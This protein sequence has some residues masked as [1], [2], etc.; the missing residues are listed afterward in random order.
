M[1]KSITPD[2]ISTILSNPSPDSS[3][4]L[5]EIIVQVIDLT[6]IG[7]RYKFTAN[8]GKMKLKAMFPSSFSSEINSGNIQNLG[9]IQVIDYTLNDIPSK[10][11]K[12]LIVTKCE[13]VSPALE[14]EF[15]TEVKSEETGILLKP[16]QVVEIQNEVKGEGT[17]I[18]LKPKQEIVAKSA[19][20]IVNEQHGNMAPAARMAMTRRVHPL[21]SLNPYQGNWTIKVRLTNKGTMCTY[22]NARGEGC[23]F[24]VELTDEDGTQIQ[25]TM[26]NEAARKFYEKFQLGKVYY[27]SKGALKV[28]N[29][30]FK[31]V[32]NDYE[33]TLNE[34]SEVEEASNEET[35]IPETKFK[36]VEIEE[37]GPYVN[38]KELVDVIGVV[39]SVSPTMSI[40]RKS[41]NDVVPKRDITIADKTKKTVVVSLWNDHAT[42]VGQ[43]L[44]DNADKFPIV[45]IKSL[46]VGDFQG[47]SLSTLSK[48]IVLVNP[49]TPESQKLRSWYDSEGKGASMASIGSD[50]SPSSKGGARSMYYDRVSLSHVTSNPS[51]GEDKPSFFS[52]R[53]YISFIKPDQTM[54]YRACK[55]CNKKVTDAIGSGYWCE[56][57]QKN[58]DECSLRYIMVVKVSDA[59]GEAWLSVFN[60][61][62][63][64]IF[65]CSADELDKLKSQEGEENLFL[66]K[67]KGAIWVPH[68]FRISVA[69]HEYMNEKRQRITARAVVP[70][71][72]AAESR[73]LLEEI[74][75]MKTS[76]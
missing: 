41:N 76:Q 48:S 27:I 47:V 22:K 44:L 66:Q 73:L 70:V 62:A 30:Q 18:F 26:F 60:E 50:I 52:I 40:R 49:E 35:F 19:A 12:Y 39:Q 63:E 6:P 29:K 45:A 75:K 3:S 59:S 20:Q 7:N 56:G 64:R 13:A 14:V 36:F 57:C 10:Q 46:K 38:G 43:E 32:Q 72:F 9:L 69:Q 2:A 55:T 21:V 1:A 37:L 16:K 23:V 24:N 33:M 65:G 31:T 67:L 4:E 51:L 8:D 71:D 17:G 74:S 5:P 54:W 34:N 11:E 61:Q 25:A 58:D 42:N 53:A 15:K 28:A 68:L